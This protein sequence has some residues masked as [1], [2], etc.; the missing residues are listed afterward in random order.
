MPV[1]RVGGQAQ[2]KAFRQV[3][4]PLRLELAQYRSLAAFAQF[5]SDLDDATSRRIARGKR[6]VESL[7]QAQF[8]PMEEAAEILA[9]HAAG[10]GLLD[11]LPLDKLSA[12]ESLL[13]D[14][15]RTGRKELWEKLRSGEKLDSSAVQEIAAA[16]DE[17]KAPMKWTAGGKRGDEE[18]HGS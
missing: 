1:S 8:T 6:L 18:S 11:D 12:F 13:I 9:I 17:C 2:T 14:S 3:A 10:S 15:V 7:K 16:V 4:G 5:G